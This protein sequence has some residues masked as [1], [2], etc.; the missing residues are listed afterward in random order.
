MKIGLLFSFDN[1]RDQR[2]IGRDTACPDF[3]KPNISC[4]G[5]QDRDQV[6]L[7]CRGDSN[8]IGQNLE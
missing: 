8:I 7:L 4:N 1:G 5:L 3:A 2:K 6:D